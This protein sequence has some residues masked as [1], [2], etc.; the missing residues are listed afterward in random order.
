MQIY[1]K[2]FLTDGSGKKISFKNCYIVF[3]C[4]LTSLS[5]L[6]KSVGFVELTDDDKRAR[7]DA[8]DRYF[9]A[10]LITRF[11][12]IFLFDP[13]DE[14]ALFE[15]AGKRLQYFCDSLKKQRINIIIDD[16]IISLLVKKSANKKEGARKLLR[17]I[18][19]YIEKP[20]FEKIYSKG[21]SVSELC[22]KI[23]VFKENI[24]IS[25]EVTV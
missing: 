25:E 8:L 23:Y 17:V 15:I 13:L 24:C 9:P 11:D 5:S 18:S 14:A 7:L 22:L 6:S 10:A 16:D 2:G 20:I 12:E 19:E 1:D 21:S 4:S 3:S